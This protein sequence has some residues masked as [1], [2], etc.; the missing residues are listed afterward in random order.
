MR[1]IVRYAGRRW[2]EALQ[3]VGALNVVDV[4]TN[5]KLTI[6]FRPLLCADL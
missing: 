6:Y 3:A 2:L 5:G 1:T 4:L